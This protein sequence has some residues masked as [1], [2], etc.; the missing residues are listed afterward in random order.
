MISA[1]DLDRFVTLQR[2]HP[3]TNEFGTTETVWTAMTTCRAQLVQAE[4]S[5]KG[6]EAG[7]SAGETIVLRMR[8]H[9]VTVA[10]RVVFE[11]ETYDITHIKQIGRRV[12]V[13]LTCEA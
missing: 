12:G 3:V 8:W 13:E 7:L 6:D 5:A 11:A 10:D 1:G 4:A 9:P 2:A